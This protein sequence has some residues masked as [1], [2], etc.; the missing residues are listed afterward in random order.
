MFLTVEGLNKK[1]ADQKAVE[2]LSFSC[3]KG[4]LVSILGPSG[5]GKTTTLR[6]LAGLE[7]PDSG[8]IYLNGEE[9]TPKKPEERRVGMVFQNYALFPHMNVEEN[10]RYGLRFVRSPMPGT[11][12]QQLIDRL[13]KMV[14]LKGY[15]KRKP[16]QLSAGQQQRVAIVRSLAVNPNLLLL[17]EPLSA[18]DAHLRSSLRLEIRRIQRELNLTTVYVTHDQEEAMSISDLVMVMR[19]G[20][21]EQIGTP[22][23]IYRRPATGFVAT[24]LGSTSLIPLSILGN[25][26]GSDKLAVLRSE[27]VRVEPSGDCSITGKLLEVEYF[28]NYLRLEVLAPSGKIWAT[29]KGESWY[30]WQKRIGEEITLYVEVNTLS[31]VPRDS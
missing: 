31:T 3:L 10:I 18:L 12:Q 11:Q 19:D 17:D 28:G 8:R 5:C 22:V 26:D 2:N 14:G 9:I 27:Q 7:T 13:L 24:F 4:Q 15:Q 20:R 25:D 21:I 1:F 23:E 16:Q 30:D 29:A 6:L